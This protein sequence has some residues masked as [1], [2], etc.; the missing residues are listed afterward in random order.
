MSLILYST[1][2]GLNPSTGTYT[3]FEP[4]QT[5]VDPNTI[6]DLGIT[7]SID[8]ATSSL[9]LG[10]DPVETQ[11]IE[12]GSA[13]VTT[14]IYGAMTIVHAINASGLI[15]ANDLN[16]GGKTTLKNVSATELTSTYLDASTLKTTTLNAT[17]TTTLGPLYAGNCSLMNVSAAKVDLNTLTAAN[18]SLINVSAARVDA[19]TLTANNVSTTNFTVGNVLST[20]PIPTGYTIVADQVGSQISLNTF[21]S[22]TPNGTASQI[23]QNQF[24]TYTST[25]SG[26]LNIIRG[27]LNLTPV[28]AQTTYRV[29][30]SVNYLN[31]P[32]DL[33]FQDD[34][35]TLFT[36]GTLDPAPRKKYLFYV[37]PTLTGRLYLTITRAALSG[38]ATIEYDFLSVDAWYET[39]LSTVN[40]TGS[41]LLASGGG[42]VG[43]GTAMPQY[44]LDVS[45]TMRVTGEVYIGSTSSTVT[46][47]GSNIKQ[48]VPLLGGGQIE[49]IVGN[50]TVASSM[51]TTFNRKF[52]TSLIP[53]ACYT[54]TSNT[55]DQWTNQ[56]F[57][58]V[59]SGAN[60][61]RGGYTYKGCFGVEKK[62]GGENITQSSVSTLF[63]YGSGISPPTTTVPPVITFS[64]TGQV[65]TLFVDTSGGNSTD[66]AFMTTLIC[67]P[68]SSIRLTGGA[69][70]D[71]I[72]NA[73]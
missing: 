33:S 69:L 43:V 31:N 29:C 40:A 20:I 23:G 60:G 3:Y 21:T 8:A 53:L 25:D 73:I 72:I 49:N 6:T 11:V 44:T 22:V 45:G 17:G 62:G 4:N 26:G 38:A 54:I 18:C 16:V 58:L 50:T 59:V 15:L 7:D 55:G 42:Q 66:Q 56:Y 70:E 47:T 28:F 67:Y 39:N 41:A 35:G 37:K 19:N 13:G 52:T 9:Q 51:S 64:R 63:Y 2:E 46:T 5:P 12:M 30:F 24:Y 61:N 14:T 27:K 1:Y 34:A 71:Y 32:V 10:T 48:V 36:I 65:L 57:E 68:T